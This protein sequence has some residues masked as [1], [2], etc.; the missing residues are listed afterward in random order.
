MRAAVVPVLMVAALTPAQALDEPVAWRDPDSGCSYWLTPQ[1]GIAPR[2]R[3]N[4]MP[5]CPDVQEPATASPLISNQALN[6][7]VRQ[8]GR[9]LEALTREVEQL[10]DR[11]QR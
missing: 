7:I 3:R 4:G 10:R 8:L 5:D 1:G 9:G 6:D 2:F 11:L